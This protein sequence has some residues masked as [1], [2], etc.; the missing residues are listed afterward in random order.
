MGMR[1]KLISVLCNAHNKV[2]DTSLFDD[3]TYAQQIEIEADYLIEN[4]VTFDKDI[5]ALTKKVARLEKS[6]R[7]WRRKHQ[8]L[9]ADSVSRGCHDQVRWERDLAIGQLEEHG[10]SFGCVAQDVVKVVRCKDCKK[11]EYDENFSGWC[12]EWRRRTLGNH[13]C[14]YGERKE[15]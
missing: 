1:E 4:G 15:K 10:I 14:S 7:N 13:F 9:K 2:T 6:N 5:N 12:T 3:V 11:W 8:R